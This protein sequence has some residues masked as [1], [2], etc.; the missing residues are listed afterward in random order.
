MHGNINV[1]GSNIWFYEQS[2]PARVNLTPPF[3]FW[4][5]LSLS[6]IT[7]TLNPTTATLHLI[8]LIPSRLVHWM[9]SGYYRLSHSHSPVCN[10]QHLKQCTRRWN[11]TKNST[12]CEVIYIYKISVVIHDGLQIAWSTLLKTK[13]HTVE[14]SVNNSHKHNKMFN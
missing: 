14:I 12:T 3:F 2:P 8:S 6:K 5:S 13:Q 11:I 1:N 7:Q 9:H 10:D 4:A